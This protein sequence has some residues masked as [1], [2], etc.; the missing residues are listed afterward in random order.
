MGEQYSTT[1][2]IIS[3][4]EN[5]EDQSSNFYEELA[6]KFTKYIDTFLPFVKES[7]TNKISITRTYQETVTDAFETGFSFENLNLSE[8][9]IDFKITKNDNISDALRKAMELE[10]KISKF[11]TVVA[12]KSKALLGTIST[13]FSRMAEKRRKRKLKLE[14]LLKNIG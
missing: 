10:E 2:T 14:E 6:K 12:E 9:K 7:K 4:A 8:S 11:Y 5:L 13:D 1:S 3:F